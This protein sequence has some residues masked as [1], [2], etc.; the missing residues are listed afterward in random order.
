MAAAPAYLFWFAGTCI[1]RSRVSPT[2]TLLGCKEGSFTL[3]Y[4]LSHQPQEAKP[5]RDGQEAYGNNGYRFPSCKRRS[6]LFD[7]GERTIA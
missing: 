6:R 1:R 5:E 7:C 3:S 2:K 4:L